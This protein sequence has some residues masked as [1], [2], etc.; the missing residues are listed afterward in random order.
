M[1]KWT[2]SVALASALAIGGWMSARPALAT[3]C[4][5][6]VGPD[7]IVGQLS[8]TLSYG[9][10]G[11]TA[12]FAIGTTSCNVGDAKLY[13][14]SWNNLHPVIGQGFFRLKNGRFEHIGQAWLKHGF[15]ALQQN[16]CCTCTPHGNGTRLGIGCSDPYDASLNGSQSGMGPKFEVNAFTGAYNYPYTG[17]GQTG[18]S[19]YKRLQARIA[20]ID[21]AQNPGALYFAEG[22]YVTADDALAGNGMNNA[23]YRRLNQFSFSSG[24]WRVTFTGDTFREQAAIRAWQDNDPSVTETDVLI[25]GEGLLLVAAKATDLGNGTYN[26]EYAVQ[27]LNSDRSVGSF[28]VPV[29]DSATVTN[30]G[31]HDV[32]YHSGEPF[33][34]TDWPG[35]FAGGAVTW[36]VTEDYATNPDANA[37]RWGTLY[38]FRFD[39]DV[40][41]GTAAVS[42]GLFKPG[43]PTSVSTTTVAPGASI[44]GDLNGDCVVDLDDLSIMLTNFGQTSGMTYEDGDID[45]DGDVD[46]DD[47]SEL[48]INF[49]GSC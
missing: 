20:D 6:P 2:C 11:T 49:G 17:Q 13:W 38:N 4:N 43:T 41:P 16:E 18:N 29:P 12:S 32:P 35:T 34:G 9:N 39:C 45:G 14:E 3:D 1:Q 37:L 31:F 22:Q 19:L 47:L 36:A 48:L 5:R 26:Y 15:T 23:S 30:I 46:L 44:N 40:A 28:S 24:Q 33:D 25:P 42:L 7:V 8:G 21:P 10:D 27:N